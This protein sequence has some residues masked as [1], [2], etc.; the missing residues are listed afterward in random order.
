M[1][2]QKLQLKNFRNHVNLNIDFN[3]K[4]T[5]I[6]GNNGI[7]KTN[8]LEAIHLLASTKSLRTNYD[9][10]MIS[11]NENIAH[12][13]AQALISGEQN[14]LELTLVKSEAFQNASSKR[15]KFNGVKKAMNDFAGKLNSVLFSPSDI[16]VF[17]GTPANRRKYLDSIFFQIDNE[18]KRAHRDFTKA[19]KQRNKLLETIRETGKGLDLIHFWDEKVTDTGEI[20]Q[21]KRGEL[22]EF[23]NENIKKHATLVNGK[24]ASVEVEYARSTINQARILYYKEREIAA[25]RTLIGPHKDDFIIKLNNYPIA[26]YGSRGQQRSTLLALKLCEIDFLTQ[27]TGHRPILLLDDIFSELDERHK[28]AVWNVVNMQQTI[29]T[30]AE[31]L[32][33]ELDACNVIRLQRNS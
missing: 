25:A 5:L 4:T 28:D 13:A 8:I 16:E 23:I 21:K 20:M 1:Q 15:A 32:T 11:H 9:R 26:V 33:Y 7:G 31:E 10:E 27:K 14:K 3:T 29:I 24:N 6:V 2:I 17:A 19:V 18:Y 12:I 30:S 22:I